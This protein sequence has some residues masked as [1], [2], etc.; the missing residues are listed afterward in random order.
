VEWAAVII[1]ALL[2]GI[3]FLGFGFWQ[4][5][6]HV[7]DGTN[8]FLPS[9]FIHIFDLSLGAL[10]ALF[11][12]ISALRFWQLSMGGK[13]GV[14]VPWWLYIKK[15]YL[16]PWHF[17]TQKRFADCEKNTTTRIYMP[18]LAHLGLMLGYV[19]MLI[20]VMVF[21]KQLQAGPEINWSVHIFGYLASLGLLIG[22]TYMLRGRL[23]KNRTQYQKSHGSDWVFLILLFII[24]LTGVTQHILHR[25]GLLVAANIIYIIHLMA[26]VP[27]LMRMPF[28][29]WAHMFLRPLA[30]YFSAVRNEVLIRQKSRVEP[31]GQA[32]RV[33]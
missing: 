20:I 1:V 31:A 29:K 12:G 9:S 6:I 22:V 23:K 7:Y 13:N 3:F 16:L 5:D 17:F 2:T 4:G 26:V 24:A 10:V 27:W 8:A 33:A 11:I 15:I 14:K 25:S 19:T 28:T 32:K 21:I 18:W 30:M